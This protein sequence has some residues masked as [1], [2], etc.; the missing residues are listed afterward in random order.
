MNSEI[1]KESLTYF[2]ISIVPILILVLTVMQYRLQK[3]QSEL[4]NLSQLQQTNTFGNNNN[5]E[6]D[7]STHYH[8]NATI[9]YSKKNY[10]LKRKLEN[11]K[12]LNKLFKKVS[13]WVL[14][15]IYALNLV[16]FIFPFPSYAP[17]QIP[18]ENLSKYINFIIL[19]IYKAVFPTILNL[20]WAILLLLI[21]LIIRKFM[22]KGLFQ[23]SIG[24]LFLMLIAFL[25]FKAILL[26][27][28][29]KI[30]NSHNF[31]P[32]I[33]DIQANTSQ[34]T[35]F[36]SNITPPFLIIFSV[37]SLLSLDTI[38]FYLIQ[39]LFESFGKTKDFKRLSILIPRLLFY[40]FMLLLIVILSLGIQTIK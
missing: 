38:A 35:D 26:I 19:S 33:T 3:R 32:N 13:P 5:I 4:E 10:Q 37:L 20:L 34:Y 15:F 29:V 30:T 40:L 11:L 18:F 36:L 7:N 8:M 12:Y 28:E 6:V 22:L 39:F 16:T 21:T 31:I 9:N 17:S 1:I 27:G 14:L 24:N 25:Y 23:K 2:S